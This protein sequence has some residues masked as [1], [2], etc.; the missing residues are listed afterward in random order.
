MSEI[1]STCS[2]HSGGVL[3]NVPVGKLE[4]ENYMEDVE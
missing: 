2:A 1:N 3:N 4:V